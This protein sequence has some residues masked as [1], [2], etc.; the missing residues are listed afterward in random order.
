MR[1]EIMFMLLERANQVK[2]LSELAASYTA[3][4]GVTPEAI[5]NEEESVMA[6]LDDGSLFT[7]SYSH[8]FNS[9]R[10][11][12]P[13]QQS[14]FYNSAFWGTNL[15][16]TESAD[17]EN[18]QSL[19]GILRDATDTLFQDGDVFDKS[20]TWDDYPSPHPITDVLPDGVESPSAIDVFTISYSPSDMTTEALAGII[21]IDPDDT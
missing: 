12:N 18:M 4:D 11:S 9:S 8:T 3:L 19:E 15:G 14:S 17:I 7:G 1:K 13:E 6:M 2:E 10:F 16:G 21:L 5:S 20:W